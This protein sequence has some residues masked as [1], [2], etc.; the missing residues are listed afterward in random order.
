MRVE[1]EKCRRKE[2]GGRD[3]RGQEGL[4]EDGKEERERSVL[5]PSEEPRAVRHRIDAF[6]VLAPR[7]LCSARLS[8]LQWGRSLAAMVMA[9]LQPGGSPPEKTHQHDGRFPFGALPW[10]AGSSQIRHQQQKHQLKTEVN[11]IKA[12]ASLA[13]GNGATSKALLFPRIK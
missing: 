1:R 7:P 6:A 12:I 9:L 5:A 11:H 4:R 8:Q 13:A 3:G 10:P 2:L